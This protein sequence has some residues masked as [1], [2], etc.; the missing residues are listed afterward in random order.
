MF[1]WVNYYGYTSHEVLAVVFNKAFLTGIFVT[2]SLFTNIFLVRYFKQQNILPGFSSAAY[3]SIL[4]VIALFV[5]FIVLILELAHGLNIYNCLPSL[6]DIVIFSFVAAY[7]LGVFKIFMNRMPQYLLVLFSIAIVI[8]HLLHIILSL[9]ENVQLRND[10]LF[11][12]MGGIGIFMYHYLNVAI[13]VAGLIII[14]NVVRKHA[15]DSPEVYHTYLWYFCFVLLFIASVEFDHLC[16]LGFYSTTDV[17]EIMK[18]SHMIGYPIIWGIASLLI[19][20][21]GLRQKNKMLRIIS[22]TIFGIIIL[23]LFVFDIRYISAGGKVAAFVILGVIM[24]LV[25]FLYQKLKKIVFGDDQD[26]DEIQQTQ[27]KPE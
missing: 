24:L 1:D 18:N 9:T 21:N 5:L 4:N 27:I 15:A 16:V 19:M 2:G 23:K 17:S 10:Y 14:K 8:T 3:R 20:I 26:D 13:V 22:L 12:N 7:L 25:S 6:F 11:S